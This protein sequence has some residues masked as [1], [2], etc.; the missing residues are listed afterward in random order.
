MKKETKETKL[1]KQICNQLEGKR[2]FLFQWSETT[3]N[4]A[5][6]EAGSEEDARLM[7]DQGEYDNDIMDCD[8]IDDSLHITEETE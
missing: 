5:I 3:D 7:W 2:K 6:I 1:R 8:Y 4:S